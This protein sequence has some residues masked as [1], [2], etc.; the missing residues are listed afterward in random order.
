[1]APTRRGGVQGLQALVRCSTGLLARPYPGTSCAA[2]SHINGSAQRNDTR[3]YSNAGST[4]GIGK[5]IL[6]STSEPNASLPHLVV[7][8]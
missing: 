2:A 1:M 5:S 4:R 3:V 6:S 7:L 8:P